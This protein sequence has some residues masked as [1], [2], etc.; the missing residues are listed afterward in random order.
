MPSWLTTLSVV[1]L[2]LAV[3]CAAW[4]AL[5]VRRRPQHMAVMNVVWPVTA[6]F[7]S[8]VAVWFYR[9]HGRP[10]VDEEPSM[11]VSVGKGALH[12]GAG[13][14]LGDIIAETAAFLVPAVLVPL[15]Y[16]GFWSERM[17][18]VW[19]L[20]F[21]LAFALGILFQ[22]HAIAPM[23]GLG[24][25]DGLVAAL[26][27]DT[28]SLVAWQVGMYGLMAVLVFGV[29]RPAFGTQPDAASPVFWFAMQWAML[30]GLA[31]AYPMNWWLVRR[32]IKERM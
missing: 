21:I 23:Q 20:D 8:L 12:C 22:Y 17:Y 25:R 6:L 24:L 4:I 3:G 14:T 29:F 16:P 18:A 9:R 26:K 7:G 15:G 11:A 13:C 1:S 31:T 32:G 27:A 19:V 30:A 28:L 2:T 10:G 5:D